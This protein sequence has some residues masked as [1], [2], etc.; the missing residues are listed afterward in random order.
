MIE[1]TRHHYRPVQ[2]QDFPT[3]DVVM[4]EAAMRPFG[5]TGV[6]ARLTRTL[7]ARARV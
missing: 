6:N 4:V 7:R 5:C 1:I 3:S 2:Y